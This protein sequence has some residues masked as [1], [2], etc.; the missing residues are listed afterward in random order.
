MAHSLAAM[1]SRAS[2][3]GTALLVAGLAACGGGGGGNAATPP[4]G[5]A[6]ASAWNGS[7]C[8][9]FA[10]RSVER[11][12]TPFVEAG[13]AVSLE[14][15]VYRPLGPA[16]ASGR[17]PTVVV[18]HG[19]TGNGDDPASFRLR[20]ESQALAQTFTARGYQVLYPQRRGRGGSDGLYDEGFRPDRSAYACEAAPAL[21]GL[22]R[23]LADVGVIA[24]H[25]AA[26][27]DVDATRLLVAGVSRGGVLA[28]RDAALHAG[29][30]RA[31]INFVGGWLGEACVDA[32]IVNRSALLAA[33]SATPGLW[34]HGEN[35]PFYSVA[36]SQGHHAA[37]TAAGGLA[38]WLL[39]RRSEPGASG[40]LVHGEPALWTAT[41][42]AFLQPLLPR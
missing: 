35:D 24:A 22:D 32:G 41:L 42:D 20:F 4:S 9:A 17:W 40:H 15:V 26:R 6:L 30:Y 25:V 19:S 13:S 33:L 39:V 10:T 2:L 23:A 37:F 29:R 7:A 3:L 12:A 14:L 21:A 11:L 18:H 38:Q 1:H 27:D 31:A 8:A 5:C 28:L 36:H 34:I 16:P